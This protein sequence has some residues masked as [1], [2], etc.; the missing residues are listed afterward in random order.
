[1]TT[2][3]TQP[4]G[5]NEATYE[6]RIQELEKQNKG[7]IRDLQGERETRHELERRFGEMEAAINTAELPDDSP[8]LKVQRLSQ[9][10]DGYIQNIVHQSLEKEVKP[11]KQSVEGMRLERQFEKAYSWLGKQEGKD[12]DEI[13]GSDLEKE[14]ARIVKEH[15][16]GNTSPFEGTKA[17]YKIYKQEL[18]E[19][20]SQEAKREETISNQAGERVSTTARTGTVRFTRDQ[21][22]KMTPQEFDKNYDAIKAAERD[23]LIS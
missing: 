12:G 10:P 7:L 18:K 19:K 5:T 6:Q 8:Q 20:E 16:L 14:L 11:L 15:G 21:I 13:V 22:M 4:Q 9:D 23:G 2:Q 1:M 17:A 3:T